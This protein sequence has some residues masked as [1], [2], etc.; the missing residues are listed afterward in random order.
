MRA[1]G[2]AIAE[3]VAR[4][5]L[6]NASAR[7]PRARPAIRCCCEVRPRATLPRCR[8]PPR[9][10]E[11]PGSS[12]SR[13]ID[14]QDFCKQGLAVRDPD[15][16]RGRRV[17][18]GL[19]DG[20]LGQAGGHLRDLA[21][22]AGARA[23]LAMM[24]PGRAAGGRTQ[25]SRRFDSRAPDVGVD[26]RRSHRQSPRCCTAAALVMEDVSSSTSNLARRPGPA[27]RDGDGARHLHGGVSR[28]RRADQSV[29]L[30]IPLLI[31]GAGHAR[32]NPKKLL[33]IRSTAHWKRARFGDARGGLRA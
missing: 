12:I 8:P 3:P 13:G 28:R 11:A 14:E 7:A 22:H 9:R 27:P 5:A 17:I 25:A 18:D 10:F 6:R 4:R 31:D 29:I 16:A 24:E 20:P 21:R 19:R 33:W 23:D 30:N 32:A 2:R 1:W 26:R 15:R